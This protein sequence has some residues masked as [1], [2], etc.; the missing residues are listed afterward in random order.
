MGTAPPGDGVFATSGKVEAPFAAVLGPP[1]FP[2]A[3][4]GSFGPSPTFIVPPPFSPLVPRSLA[5]PPA[6]ASGGR[7]SAH[8]PLALDR[9]PHQVPPLGPAAVVVAHLRVPQQP[10]EHEPGVAAALADTAVDDH[11]V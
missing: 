5:R 4:G 7:R 8:R 1:V 2:D 6:L 11:V 10:G 3:G 9:R